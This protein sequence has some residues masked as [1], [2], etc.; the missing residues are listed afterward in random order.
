MD[1]ASMLDKDFVG[2]FPQDTDYIYQPTNPI[3]WYEPNGNPH[4]VDPL[5]TFAPFVDLKPDVF[6]VDDQSTLPSCTGNTVVTAAELTLKRDE[7]PLSLSWLFPYWVGRN[8]IDELP[9]QK[10]SSVRTAVRAGKHF[11][12]CAATLWPYNPAMEDVRPSDA[13]F[14][15]A[16]T[17]RVQRYEIIKPIYLIT[18]TPEQ[19]KAN[20]ILQIKSALNE[21]IP[22]L[23]S[24]LLNDLWFGVTGPWQG[25]QYVFPAPDHPTIG[26]HA[27]LIIGYDDT[28]QRFLIENSWGPS[29]GDG[30]FGGMPYDALY[31]SMR[32]FFVIRGFDGIYINDPLQKEWD[33][34]QKMYLGFYGRPADLGGMIY[35]RDRLIKEGFG[36]I[37]EAFMTSPEASAIYDSKLTEANR[38]T[39]RR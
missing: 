19:K 12:L 34:I 24:C 37:V 11:G 5:P 16:M 9:G 2:S 23:F 7:R 20:L 36:A 3:V 29:W 38:I 39:R 1:Y 22:V 26:A 15:E 33:W 27:M 6:E 18:W 32:E 30:G 25:Q 28:S 17:R 8:L 35:W 14:T 13:A 21:G 31:N 10:G 4:P